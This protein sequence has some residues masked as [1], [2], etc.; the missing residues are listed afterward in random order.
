MPKIND[1]LMNIERN[2]LDKINEVNV[3]FDTCVQICQ[4]ACN[5]C[6]P[7]KVVKAQFQNKSYKPRIIEGITK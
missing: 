6:L 3:H 2:I 7:V 1:K 5:E 4:S